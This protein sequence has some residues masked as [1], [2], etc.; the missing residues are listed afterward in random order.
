MKVWVMTKKGKM[1]QR[2]IS[3]EK[4]IAGAIKELLNS[5]DISYKDKF[6]GTVAKPSWDIS[7]KNARRI[8]RALRNN[9]SLPN[10]TIEE[11]YL[12]K[13]P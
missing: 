13:E 3:K 9:K 2:N 1:V 5:H 12:R 8:W 10:V 7:A 11:K 6:R 4:V